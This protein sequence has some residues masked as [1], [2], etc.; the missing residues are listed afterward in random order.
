MPF[1][2]NSTITAF[3]ALALAATFWGMTLPFMKITL[4][5]VPLFSLAF[6]RFFVASLVL[7]PFIYKSVSFKKNDIWLL[8]LCSVF[9]VTLTISFAFWGLTL[10][11]AVNA[12]LI[13]GTVPLFS[14]LF[15]H[16]FLREKY[17]KRITIGALLGLLGLFVIVG[18]DIYESGLSFSPLG[19]LVTFL[20]V[21][22]F[23]T[24][25]TI[26]KKLSHTYSA[27]QIVAFI[28]FVGSLTFLPAAFLELQTKGNWYLHLPFVAIAGILFGIFFSSL[29][30]FLLW[31]YGLS[32]ISETK[33]GFFSYLIP[34]VSTLIAIT[35]LGEKFG[36]TIFIGAVLIFLG[37]FVAEVHM[38]HK[39][40][41]H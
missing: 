39:S 18:K 35:F 34:I 27:A 32:K 6:L 36:L 38:H 29:G 8:L 9:G 5:Y 15:A 31:Q 26:S 21:L 33:A 12:G 14:I 13:S 11:T 28:F 40:H 4:Q 16:I 41:L 10:T 20:N 17:S 30:A 37:L 1:N 3:A 22:C 2:K 19:D 7:F 25:N 23:A 24:Y